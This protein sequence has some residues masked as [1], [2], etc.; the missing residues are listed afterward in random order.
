MSFENSNGVSELKNKKPKSR[1][2]ILVVS[3]GTTYEET[4]KNTIEAIEERIAEIFNDYEIR[5]AFTSSIIR[6]ILKKRDSIIALSPEEALQKMYDDGFTEI[7]VQSLHLLP[8]EEYHEKII[9]TVKAYEGVFKKIVV[10]RP[11]LSIDKDYDAVI[12]AI[13]KQVPPLEENQSVVLMGHGSH[14]PA[15]ACY[16]FLQLKL[17]DEIPNVFIGNVEGYPTLEDILPKLTRNGIEEIILMPFMLVAG[18]HARTDMAGDG[19]DSWK[20]ILQ[21]KGFTVKT[22]TKGLGENL[23]FQDIYIRHIKDSINGIPMGYEPKVHR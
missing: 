23:A 22:Y 17:I 11:V 7:I 16:S 3:F 18:V 14:H 21:K 9:K 2:G 15:N 20:N 10:G 12:D 8:G 1:K 13:K 19:D 6:R 4:R 5:S